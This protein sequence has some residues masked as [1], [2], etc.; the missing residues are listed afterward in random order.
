[1]YDGMRHFLF[2][3]PAIF[4]IAGFAFES[5]NELIKKKWISTLS[6]VIVVLPGII[7]IISLHPYEYTYYNSFIGGTDGAFRHYETDYWLTCYKEAVEKFNKLETQPVNLYVHREADV[8]QPYAA[9]NIKV[10]DERGA[11]N[12]IQSGDFLLINT[13][14]NEDR[15]SFHEA[16][17]ILSIGRTGATF[18][19]IKEIP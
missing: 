16:P 7:G 12:Q 13:R 9:Q 10:L 18:C 19:I 15:K 8:A 4:I 14:S 11:E 1:M 3:L 6:L 5:L 2:I 17:T